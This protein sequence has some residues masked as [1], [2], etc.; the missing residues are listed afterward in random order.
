M[1]VTAQQMIS[2]L[3]GNALAA[4]NTYKGKRVTVTGNVSN[5]DASGDYFSITGDELS[6]TNIMINI[7][8][9]HLDTVSSFSE[10]QSVTV[11]GEVTDV[12]E[13]LG[14]SIKAETIE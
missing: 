8:E 7:E 3:E 12:G 5:I 14:Y 10:G 2:D 1:E 11:T 6:F 4:S 9:E 13:I